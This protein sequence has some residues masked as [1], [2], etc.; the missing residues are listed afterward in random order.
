MAIGG[1]DMKY[2]VEDSID[3]TFENIRNIRLGSGK[4][5]LLGTFRFPLSTFRLNRMVHGKRLQSLRQHGNLIAL[6]E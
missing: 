4:F 3:P 5:F 2:K 6:D 1:S